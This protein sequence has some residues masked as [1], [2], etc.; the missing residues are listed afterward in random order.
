M[1]MLENFFERIFGEVHTVQIV[2]TQVW[3]RHCIQDF[4]NDVLAKKLSVKAFP[5]LCQH[6]KKS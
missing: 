2:Q 5:N 3:V 6:Q 4:Y 1:E